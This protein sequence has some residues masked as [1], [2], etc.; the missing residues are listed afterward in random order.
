MNLTSQVPVQYC[1]LQHRTLLSPPDT[2]TAECHFCFG[3]AASFFLGLLV[4]TLHSSPA[5][6]WT[7][8]DL[9]GSSSTVISFCLFILFMGFSSQEYWSG[10]SFPPPVDHIFSGL[11]TMTC[12]S[13]V[14][15]HSTVHNFIEL[16]KPL[17]HNK[18]MIQEG[19][20]S[21]YVVKNQC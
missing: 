3:S 11:F 18:A 5:T 21:L 4:I 6:Y 10:L 13:W 15:L 17:Q 12:L 7:P 19:V 2:S 20:S 8:S 1:S 14:A 16:H 9:E